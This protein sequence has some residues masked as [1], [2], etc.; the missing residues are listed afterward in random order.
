MFLL[1]VILSLKCFVLSRTTAGGA[2]LD[3]VTGL[4]KGLRRD[5]SVISIKCLPSENTTC[6]D[7]YRSLDAIQ[8]FH[9]DLFPSEKLAISRCYKKQYSEDQK[10]GH[11]VHQRR[12]RFDLSI[13]HAGQ[14]HQIFGE[15]GHSKLSCPVRGPS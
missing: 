15:T 10:K 14:S 1:S 12:Q 9:I 5:G 4:A 8:A 11:C 7:I 6:S 13:C 2:T 3:A